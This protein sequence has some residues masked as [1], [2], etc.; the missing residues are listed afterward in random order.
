MVLRKL[1]AH[2]RAE[3]AC[4]YT[5]CTSSPIVV[6]NPENPEVCLLPMVSLLLASMVTR[7]PLNTWMSPVIPGAFPKAACETLALVPGF[8][9]CG[10]VML[11]M[12]EETTAVPPE[13]LDELV[14]E[15]LE[16]L[17][18]LLPVLEFESELELL[19]PMRDERRSFAAVD[20]PVV[21]VPFKR[22]DV[23]LPDPGT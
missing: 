18:L 2:C 6:E 11:A 17:L 8:R 7:L 22:S 21:P 14:E 9:S 3:H 10:L 15:V 12:T 13:E 4:V 5:V 19:E 23:E 1:F 16:L 20:P